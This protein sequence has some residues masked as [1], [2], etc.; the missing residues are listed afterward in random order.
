MLKGGPWAGVTRTLPTPVSLSGMLSYVT[1][2]QEC[3]QNGSYTRGYR[4]PSDHPFHCWVF[5]MR[6]TDDTFLSGKCQNCKKAQKTLEWP[7]IYDFSLILTV[8]TIR[9][10]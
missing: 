6:G 4:Q 9:V 1:E 5:P 10:S 8:L 7:T 3:A 2:Y